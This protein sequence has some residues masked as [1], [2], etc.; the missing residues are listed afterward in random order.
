MRKN[1]AA[2]SFCVHGLANRVT[3]KAFYELADGPLS[4]P[5]AFTCIAGGPLNAEGAFTC[6]A[7][8]P[9]STP[10]AFTNFSPGFPNPGLARK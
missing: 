2:F 6:I 10:K 1:I 3:P 9:L 7:D 5:K 4:T 8:G